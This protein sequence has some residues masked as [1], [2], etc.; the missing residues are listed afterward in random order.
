MSVFSLFVRE[1]AMTSL[2]AGLFAQD[3]F[4]RDTS[5]VGSAPLGAGG[6]VQTAGEWQ[7]QAS[8]GD[9]PAKQT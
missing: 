6:A 4:M 1:E 3:N 2:L 9:C 8:T 5:R 7:R